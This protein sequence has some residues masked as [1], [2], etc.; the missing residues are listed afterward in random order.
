[1]MEQAER[2]REQQEALRLEKL[3]RTLHH[4]DDMAVHQVG[5]EYIDVERHNAR[6]FVQTLQNFV[7]SLLTL[8]SSIEVDEAVQEFSAKYCQGLFSQQQI[9]PNNTSST[10][11][12]TL[13]TIIN[14]DG[15]YL[16]SYSALLLNLKLIKQGYYQDQHM[17]P[18][19]MTEEQF[20]E[21]VHGSGVLV[22]LSDTWLSELYQNIL[23]SSL[24]EK[25]GYST[26]TSNNYALI[27]L[28]TDLD[29]L[30]S[31]QQGGQLLSDCQRLERAATHVDTS[32]EVDAGVKLSRRV[33]SCCWDSMLSVLSAG[34]G[35]LRG[36]LGV[37]S[38]LALLL[39]SEVA[40]E[41]HRR[42]RESI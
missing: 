25:C 13:I 35:D 28:L 33:L 12:L 21:G 30:G 6:R 15:I 7:P 5:E 39:G 31:C 1:M 14:A 11:N 34:L 9:S 4:G 38:S 18:V 27:N 22:Y 17:K 36:Q 29:G 32:P 3:P 20:V 37:T 10:H 41:E 8:R 42:A 19:P 2:Q 23:A 40:R 24:L 16:A 26:N